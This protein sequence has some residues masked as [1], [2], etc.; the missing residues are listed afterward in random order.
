[1]NGLFLR[2]QLCIPIKGYN[3]AIIYDINRKDYYFIANEHYTVLNTNNFI[4]FNK[5]RNDNEREELIDFLL[6]E[7]IIFKV[8]AKD[9]KNRFTP[10]KR[11][12]ATPNLLTNA[13]VHTNINPFFF[14]FIETEYI[15]NLSIIAPSIND[16]LLKVLVK[17]EAL[18][19]DNV[20]LYIENFD[21]ERFEK[22]RQQL[23]IY[24][25]VF[26]VNFFGCNNTIDKNKLYNNI[27]FNFFEQQFSDYKQHFTIDNLVVN[28]DHFL[29]SYNY[30][31]YYFGKVYID[32][33]GNIKN[34]LN[35]IENF[36]N[37]NTISKAD[38]FNIIS[39]DTFSELGKINKNNTL[40]CSDCEFRYMCIDSRV[41]AKGA[42]KWYHEVEC[43][44]NPYLSKWK[45]EDGY[46]NLEESGVAVT[47]SGIA[48]EKKKL[49]KKFKKVWSII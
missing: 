49:T 28:S 17:V 26:S 22:D 5:I 45:H 41:P 44:Y 7:E 4:N 15:Q 14:N 2:N 11:G 25:L 3:R 16:D 27:Y 37:L 40:V 10:L 34:G 48:I 32:E 18:E 13:V 42:G 35:N 30:H 39:S 1:M 46:I 29:E 36:G 47:E 19:I 12:L 43:S 24:N 31:S 21:N 6:K 33:N 8:S 20:Y 23:G 38:F 9:N